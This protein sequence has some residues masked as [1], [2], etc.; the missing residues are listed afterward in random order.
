MISL[1]KGTYHDYV[2]K[3]GKLVGQFEKMYRECDDP[4]NQSKRCDE[5]EIKIMLKLLEWKPFE[6]S[7]LELGC[8]YGHVA[9]SLSAF[10]KVRAIDISPTAI[11]KAIETYKHID[12]YVIDIRKGINFDKQFNLIV[13][14]GTLWY[15]VEHID[16][17]FQDIKN[18]LAPSGKFIISLPFPPLHENYYGKGII[19]DEKELAYWVRKYFKIEEQIVIYHEWKKDSPVV[20]IRA[21]K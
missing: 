16:T 10:G 20:I 11:N 9:N 17:I 13:L 6:N 14:S 12:F 19:K 8:G 18:H 4:W 7:I 3:N 2:I 21:T 1:K 15:V 5:L